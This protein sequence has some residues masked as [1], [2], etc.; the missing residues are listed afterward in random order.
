MFALLLSELCF[1]GKDTSCNRT[2]NWKKKGLFPS[3][4]KCTREKKNEVLCIFHA[5]IYCKP[6]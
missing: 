4:I 2:V 6:I 1:N 5:L 3:L